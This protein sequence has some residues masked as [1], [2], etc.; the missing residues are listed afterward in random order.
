M[1]NNK[2]NSGKIGLSDAE[3]KIMSE[4]WEHEPMSITELSEFFAGRTGW[5]KSTVIT[6][7]KRMTAKGAVSFKQDGRTKRFFSVIKRENVAVSETRSFLERLY[8]GS[9][10]LMLNSLIEQDALTSD[11][12]SELY[13][14][15]EKAKKAGEEKQ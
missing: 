10:G 4:L 12:I 5:S 3:W 2:N 8:S 11:E 13:D 7:L 1:N 9:P 14:I 6:L 15:L